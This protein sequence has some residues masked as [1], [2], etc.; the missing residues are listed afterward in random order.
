MELRD[1]QEQAITDLAKSLGRGNK[2]IILQAATGSGKTVMASSIVKRAVAKGNTVLFLAHRRELITQCSNKLNLFGIGHGI[3]MSGQLNESWHSVQIASVDTLRARALSSRRMALPK[4]DIIIIDECHRTLSKTYRKIIEEYD[5]CVVLGLTATPCRGDGLGLGHVYQ[6]MVC[7]PTIKN[8]TDSGHLVPTKYFAPSIPDL[9]GI[10][11]VAGDYNKK[12]LAKKMDTPK[13]VGDV[14]TNWLS[15]ANG[16][17]TVIFASSVQHSINLKESFEKIGIAVGHIDGST[18]TEERDLTLKQ[19]EDGEITVLC[20]CL[21]L[22]EGWDCP[23]AEVCVLARPTKSLGLYLQMVGRVLRPMDG[24]DSA[25]IIDHSG[26]VYE[27]GFIDDEFEWD[28]DPAKKIQEKKKST[29]KRVSK[30]ITCEKCFTVYA[31]VRQCPSCGSVHI[32]KGRSLFVGDGEL[33]EIDRKSRKIKKKEFTIDQKKEW[34]SMLRGYA[35]TRGYKDGWAFYKYHDKFGV[36]PPWSKTPT[37]KPSKECL[38][39]IT[40]IN[41]R[42]SKRKSA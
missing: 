26:A 27:H 23:S 22:T 34:Y 30:P 39:W 15:I 13:L 16:K 21:V 41:I 19:L 42:N 1:Y 10:K 38:S 18:P 7:A 33:G 24:K 2:R 14:V 25:T 32:K 12:Q 28:L 35:L 31:G 11:M 8:L 6:D 17:T 5:G 9:Q 20:N 37:L 29:T 4:A 3:I 40:Y 36:A